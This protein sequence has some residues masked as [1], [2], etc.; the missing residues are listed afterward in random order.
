MKYWG[1]IPIPN[2][3]EPKQKEIAELYHKPPIYPEELNL[4]NFLVEDSKWNK[5]AGIIEIDKSVKKMKDFLN[6]VL[7]K[8]INNEEVQIDFSF[9]EQ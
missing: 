1:V 2:F 4:K 8:I 6:K 9:L 3:S 5:Q 7:D